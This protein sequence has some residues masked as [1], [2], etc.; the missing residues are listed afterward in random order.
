MK[1]MR[2]STTAFRGRSLPQNR[3]KGVALID[4]VEVGHLGASN[5]LE[6]MKP[7]S[8]HDQRV[9]VILMRA[10]RLLQDPTP[11]P[12][13]KWMHLIGVPPF[14]PGRL[15]RQC[16]RA[17]LRNEVD[18]VELDRD[19]R[20]GQP[21]ELLQKEPRTEVV[22]CKCQPQRPSSRTISGHR[23]LS[24]YGA[25]VKRSLPSRR[26]VAI[27]MQHWF[28]QRSFGQRLARELLRRGIEVALLDVGTDGRNGF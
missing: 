18:T 10:Q 9:Q 27:F 25:S 14:R 22:G 6:W 12:L 1:A 2:R 23:P 16:R 24:D 3:T 17:V 7:T 13:H 19:S 4:V 20:F 21:R 15:I 8:P 28:G 5:A 11:P 26:S